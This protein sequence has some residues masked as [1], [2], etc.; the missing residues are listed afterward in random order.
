MGSREST[1]KPK[2]GED[3]GNKVY[4]TAI[5][6]GLLAGAVLVGCGIAALVA[7]ISS[8]SGLDDEDEV[9]EDKKTMKAPGR[10]YRIY[11]DDFEEDPATYFRNLR[12]LRKWNPEQGL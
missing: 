9:H 3:S 12:N 7:V 5:I 11:R 1:E 8:G 4:K 2:A 10:D 6:G